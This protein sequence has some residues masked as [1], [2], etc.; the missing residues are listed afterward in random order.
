LPN[1]LT[2]ITKSRIKQVHSYKLTPEFFNWLEIFSKKYK[3]VLIE[4]K[5]NKKLAEKTVKKD[6]TNNPKNTSEV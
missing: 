3:N 6:L 1:N 2:S 4:L 5:K